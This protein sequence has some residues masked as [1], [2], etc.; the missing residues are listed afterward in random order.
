MFLE[1]LGGFSR[2]FEVFGSS[3]RFTEC[4]FRFLRILCVSWRLLEIIE[5]S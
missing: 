1:V 3:W 5:C 2:I 4:L